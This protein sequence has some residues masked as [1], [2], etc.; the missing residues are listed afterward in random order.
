MASQIEAERKYAL[1]AGQHLPSLGG[2]AIEG[3]VAEHELVATYY[4]APDFRLTRAWQVIRHRTGGTD[5]GWHLKLP[6]GP[7]QRLEVHAPGGSA[8]VPAELRS[9]VAATLAGAPLLPV[10]VLRT[11]RREQQLLSPD[12]VVLALTCTDHVRAEVGRRREEWDE[13]EVELVAGDPALADRIE[14]VLAESGIERAATGSKIARALAGAM[15][16]SSERTAGTDPS[17]GEVVLAYAAEQVGILQDRESDVL[18]DGPD[19]VHRSRVATRRLRSALRSYAGVFEAGTVRGLRSELRWHAE[20]LGAPRDAEVLAER[21]L[22]ATAEL[23]AAARAEVAGPLRSTLA[24]THAEAHAALVASM[25][26]DRYERLQLALAGL[27]AAPP[28]TH[29]AGEPARTVLR[30][31]LAKVIGRVRR[32]AAHAAARPTD[33]TRWHEVRKAA[34]AARYGAEVLLPVIPAAAELL[35][36]RWESVTEA[37]GAV[38]DAVVAQ[39]VIGELSWQAVAA[40]RSRA[41]FDDLRHHQD[42]R[43]RE[44]LTRGRNALAEALA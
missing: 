39:Q 9:R 34:K 31:M 17:A 30:P 14:A 20:E 28:L 37:F 42:L 3:P 33:L 12:G 22:A 44:S 43:L 7:D 10:A 38:Q 25:H 18:V 1:A 15:T 13:A 11:L 40:G 2:V 16:T 8:R 36:S 23:P 41:P 26:T 32:V 35:R 6:A 21:L 27:L 29:A 19:S 5:P 4:D 24:R